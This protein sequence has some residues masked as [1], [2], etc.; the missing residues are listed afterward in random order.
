MSA[1][2]FGWRGYYSVWWH[3]AAGSAAFGK[4]G[5]ESAAVQLQTESDS[6]AGSSLSAVAADTPVWPWHSV[7]WHKRPVTVPGMKHAQEV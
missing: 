7:L 2:L 3:A 5:D 4:T 6:V 1:H